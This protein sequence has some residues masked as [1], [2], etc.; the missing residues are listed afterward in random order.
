MRH[1]VK[2]IKFR[3]GQDANEMLMRKLLTNF[4]RQGKITTTEQKG[5]KL[6]TLIE[7][8]VE[9]AKNNTEANKNYLLKKINRVE[10]IETLFNQIGPSLVK[11]VGGYV[12][13]VRLNPRISDGA[14]MIKLVWAQPMVIEDKQ[15]EP[16]KTKEINKKSSVAK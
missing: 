11:K 8:I 16:K 6:K 7:K 9:K 13:M 5:K 2:K 12:K 4:I 1:R 14:T 10:F 15:K 3:F